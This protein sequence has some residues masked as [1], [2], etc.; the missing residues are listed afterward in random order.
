MEWKVND[1]YLQV[2][3][4]KIWMSRGEEERKYISCEEIGTILT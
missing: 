4:T 2:S 3:S 1:V